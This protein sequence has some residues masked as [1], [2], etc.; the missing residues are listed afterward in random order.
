MNSVLLLAATLVP[1][2]A[3]GLCL[4]KPDKIVYIAVDDS[5]QS[6]IV[7]HLSIHNWSKYTKSSEDLEHIQFL[8]RLS[9]HVK[10][11]WRFEFID[12]YSQAYPESDFYPVFRFGKIGRWECFPDYAL[13]SSDDPLHYMAWLHDRFYAPILDDQYDY[14]DYKRCVTRFGMTR[15]GQTPEGLPPLP[16]PFEFDM[17]ETIWE[18]LSRFTEFKPPKK[19]LPYWYP[20]DFDDHKAR[21][22]EILML[23]DSYRF[24]IFMRKL[25][26]DFTLGKKVFIGWDIYSY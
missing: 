3:Q 10:Y 21:K 19:Y 16:E 12:K 14:L 25:Y 13:K 7:K 22:K 18:K 5:Y 2:H 17:E 15:S 23:P 4:P 1:L 26:N 6:G 20:K 11:R 24:R 9:L 8:N